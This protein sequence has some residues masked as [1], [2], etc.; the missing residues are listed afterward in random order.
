MAT[1]TQDASGTA[2]FAVPSGLATGP[3]TF[4]AVAK[5]DGGALG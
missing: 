4:R 1:T 5:K 2:R 3:Q